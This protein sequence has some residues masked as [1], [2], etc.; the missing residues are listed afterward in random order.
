MR[1]ADL[2]DYGVNR[3]SVLHVALR[4]LAV[5]VSGMPAA[6]AQMGQTIVLLANWEMD[7]WSVD[8]IHGALIPFGRASVRG[9]CRGA[10]PCGAR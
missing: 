1:T 5:L 10:P 7:T 2:Q 8:P 9:S 6:E 3:D 4:Y